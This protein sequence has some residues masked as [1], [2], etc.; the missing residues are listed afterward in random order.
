MSR[1]ADPF[2]L[3]HPNCA[4]TKNRWYFELFF[5][6]RECYTLTRRCFY[7]RQLFPENRKDVLSL[8]VYEDCLH[9]GLLCLM[10]RPQWWCERVLQDPTL[11]PTLPDTGRL[12]PPGAPQP[13]YLYRLAMSSAGTKAEGNMSV[14]SKNGRTKKPVKAWLIRKQPSLSLES[15]WIY[16]VLGKVMLV[17]WFFPSLSPARWL[18][19]SGTGLASILLRQARMLRLP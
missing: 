4:F 9:C 10:L 18:F 3:D 11:T 16:E 15:A 2:A 6:L 1:R 12:E 19:L 17:P 13:A 7:G 14:C 8:W 5:Y